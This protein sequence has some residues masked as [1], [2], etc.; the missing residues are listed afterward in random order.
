V[1]LD[2]VLPYFMKFEDYHGQI[3]PTVV[4]MA[5]PIITPPFQSEA[6]Q[7]S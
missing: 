1:G 7:A 4:L 2:A 3:T 6:A 5:L